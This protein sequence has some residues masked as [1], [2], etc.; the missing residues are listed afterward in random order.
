MRTNRRYRVWTRRRSR[1]SILGLA[2]LPMVFVACS[3]AGSTAIVEVDDTLGSPTGGQASAAAID[4]DADFDG[5][6]FLHRPVD[7][8]APGFTL[9]S[10]EGATVSLSDFSGKWVLIDWVFTN[11]VTFCPLLTGGM[12]VVHSGLGDTV[13]E[14]VQLVTITFDPTRDTPEA[15]RAYSRGVAPDQ[16]GWTW[17]TG[18]AEETSAVAAAYGVSFDPGEAV[19]GVAQFDHTSLLVVIDPAGR[20]KHRYFG[21][22][23]SE[24]V[25]ER[26]E[27]DISGDAV[28]AEPTAVV[29][30]PVSTATAELLEPAIALPW[31]DWELEDGISSQVLYQF[32]STGQ[33]ASFVKQVRDEADQRGAAATRLDLASMRVAMVPGD[34]E[35]FTGIGYSENLAVVVDG[36]SWTAVFRALAIVD[37]DWCCS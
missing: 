18:T 8:A 21:S 13:G 7:R 20:E 14:S 36:E 24:D 9:T 25:L 22:G 19:N 15:L 35:A 11:C 26:L 28:A 2:L 23:W 5:A 33:L 37:N 31:E 16:T 29:A 27:A 3:S 4:T 34:E 32:P 10:Q 1:P 30:D 6:P 17:L 12:N